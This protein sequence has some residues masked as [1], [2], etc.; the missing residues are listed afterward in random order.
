M[1]AMVDPTWPPNWH[2][3]IDRFVYRRDVKNTA[4][5]V[6]YRLREPSGLTAFR[7]WEQFSTEPTESDKVSLT[8]FYL[9]D[10]DSVLVDHQIAAGERARLRVLRS[11]LRIQE[12]DLLRHR[13]E[14]VT[15]IVE[16]EISEILQDDQVDAREAWLQVDLQEALGLSYD[17]YARLARATIDTKIR[18]WLEGYK[19]PINADLQRR[20]V[21]LDSL[22]R[23][24][25]SESSP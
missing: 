16:R 9:F 3:T 22:I 8:D 2:E 24:E 19:G 17:E 13:P 20:L 5:A 6:L 14:E 21:A 18:P 11:L 12:G 25:G 7:I 4:R 15:R 1:S 10:L 23:V